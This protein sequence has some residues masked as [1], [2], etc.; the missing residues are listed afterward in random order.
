MV[1]KGKGPW[2]RNIITINFLMIFFGGEEKMKTR[3]DNGMVKLDCY[4]FSKLHVLG[5]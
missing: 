3:Q 1:G 4:Y 2:Q 5:I